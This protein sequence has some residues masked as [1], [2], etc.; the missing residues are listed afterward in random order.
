MSATII[1][2]PVVVFEVIS[3]DSARTDRI[4]KL[5]EYLATPSIRRYAILEQKSI[6]AMVFSRR[7]EIWT[8][9]ALTEGDTRHMPEI[10]AEIPLSEFYAGMNLPAPVDR[11]SAER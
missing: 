6:G 8:V 2:D 9:I 10:G 1:E 4:E 5:R 7:G 11:S 3:E